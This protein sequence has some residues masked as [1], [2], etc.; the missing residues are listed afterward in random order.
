MW[1]GSHFTK[2]KMQCP[3]YLWKEWFMIAFS[4][5]NFTNIRTSLSSP[6]AWFSV[7]FHVNRVEWLKLNCLL[8]FIPLMPQSN[9]YRMSSFSLSVQSVCC[10]LGLERDILKCTAVCILYKYKKKYQEH[11]KGFNAFIFHV[12]RVKINR[13]IFKVINQI[14]SLL[15]QK[16]WKPSKFMHDGM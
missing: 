14:V 2:L 10:H 6:W 16:G 9:L 7:F 4:V 5:K 1:L 11:L 13:N 8:I 15:C 3:F 12:K